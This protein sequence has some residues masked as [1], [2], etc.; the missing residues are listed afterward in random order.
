MFNDQD[1]LDDF[2]W[3]YSETR[4]RIYS[5]PKSLELLEAERAVYKK[6]VDTLNDEQKNLLFDFENAMS[7]TRGEVEDIIF[8]RGFRVGVQLVCAAFAKR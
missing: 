7:E 3:W 4:S 6:L 1:L 8:R 5:S 2:I